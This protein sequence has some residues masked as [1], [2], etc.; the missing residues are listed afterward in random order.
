M[1]YG[2]CFEDIDISFGDGCGEYS[3]D[4]IKLNYFNLNEC[5]DIGWIACSAFRSCDTGNDGWC[6]LLRDTACFRYA[7]KTS[8]FPKLQLVPLY[9]QFTLFLYPKLSQLNVLCC[10]SYSMSSIPTHKSYALDLIANGLFDGSLEDLLKYRGQLLYS[11]K[12]NICIVMGSLWLTKDIAETILNTVGYD[13]IN[14]PWA[15]AHS[16]LYIP[17]DEPSAG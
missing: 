6:P 8:V 2:S 10:D 3:Y 4:K 15:Y 7:M 5:F 17:K 14:K 9:S 13:H 16:T 11:E 12:Y 1:K